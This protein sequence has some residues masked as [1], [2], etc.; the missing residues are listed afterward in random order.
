MRP[1]EMVYTTATSE[2]CFASQVRMFSASTTKSAFL[3]TSMVP[4]LS[5][6]R[7][8][9]ALT[10]VAFELMFYVIILASIAELFYF[11]RESIRGRNANN[12]PQKTPPNTSI[13]EIV[14]RYSLTPREKDVFILLAEGR[15]AREIAETLFISEGTVKVHTHNLYQKLG[16]SKRS[17]IY[18]MVLDIAVGSGQEIV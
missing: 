10:T 2:M 3:P 4:I 6:I 11:F 9:L 14:E 13:S 17:Q 8:C 7:I 12:K 15:S 18:Q 16:I 5:S 1:S